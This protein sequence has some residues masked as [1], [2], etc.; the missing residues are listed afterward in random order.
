MKIKI[1]LNKSF[2]E[3][4]HGVHVMYDNALGKIFIQGNKFEACAGSVFSFDIED[5]KAIN[6]TQLDR[7]IP[8][9]S[10]EVFTIDE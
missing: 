4:F 3:V 10:G 9:R 2:K 6:I 7:T 8:D 1:N 5:G